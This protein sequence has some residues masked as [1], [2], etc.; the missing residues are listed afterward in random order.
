MVWPINSGITHYK[1]R[2]EHSITFTAMS[3]QTKC[4]ILSYINE[5]TENL[6]ATVSRLF[7]DSDVPDLH[8]AVTAYPMK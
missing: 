4:V 3:S 6:Q 8:T 7:L 2:E 5:C 1:G